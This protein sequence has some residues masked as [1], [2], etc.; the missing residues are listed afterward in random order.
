MSSEREASSGV[1]ADAMLIPPTKAVAAASTFSEVTAPERKLAKGSA[2]PGSSQWV[3]TLG[4]VLAAVAVAL[5]PW[6]AWLAVRLPSRHVSSHWDVAWVGFDFALTALLAT[7]GVALW[8]RSP[9]APFTA[10]AAATLLI[11]DAWF[12]IF[13]ARS[14][15]ELGWAILAAALVELPLAVLCFWLVRRWSLFRRRGAG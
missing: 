3:R 1:N 5:I 12:D 9:L 4:I 11:M 7:T 8:K 2:R 13:T 15:D 14:G 10:T 6:T